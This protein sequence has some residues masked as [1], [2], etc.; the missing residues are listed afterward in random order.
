MA[1]INS[2]D[3]QLNATQRSFERYLDLR[4]VTNVGL[5]NL[6]AN[7]RIRLERYA[8]NGAN[9]NAPGSLI[10]ITTSAVVG[11]SIR[12]DFG[13]NGLGGIGRAGNGFYRVSIDLD[14]DGQFDDGRFEFFRLFGDANGDGRV[15]A[16]DASL[17]VDL[18]GDGRA[19]VRDRAISRDQLGNYV[20]LALLALIDD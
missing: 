16:A 18:N 7:Q 19:D 20:D 11:N 9:V 12:L 10:P 1:T 14:A 15:D 17:L 6:I 8:T 2:I 13:S 5:Q 3:V 4:F